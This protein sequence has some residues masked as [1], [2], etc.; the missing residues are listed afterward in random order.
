LAAPYCL[1]AHISKLYSKVY[2]HMDLDQQLTSQTLDLYQHKK[3]QST[4]P[5]VYTNGLIGP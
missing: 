2:H 4:T 3:R 5:P 1:P